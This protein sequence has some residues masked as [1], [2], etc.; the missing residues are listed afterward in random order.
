MTA[1]NTPQAIQSDVRKTTDSIQEWI[2]FYLAN[3]LDMQP[4][5]VDSETPFESYGLDSAAAVAMTGDLEDWL[6][7]ELEPTLVYDYPTIEKLASY[8]GNN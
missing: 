7:Y 2:T 5:D 4:D 1:I 6:G 3:L 8:L